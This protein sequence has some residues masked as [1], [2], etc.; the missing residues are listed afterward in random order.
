MRIAASLFAGVAALAAASFCSSTFAIAA[1]ISVEPEPV[2]EANW[3]VSIHGG[4]KF[5]EDWDD[6]SEA[7]ILSPDATFETED[8]WRFGGSIGYVFSSFLALE[9]E[10]SYLRQ[11]FDQLTEDTE[12]EPGEIG[13][14]LSVLTGMV[15]IIAG[16]PLGSFV[17]PYVGA[18]I[19]VAHVSFDTDVNIN[20]GGTVF[21]LDDSDNSFAAQAFAGL[22]LMLSDRVAIG[23]R[24]RIL[25]VKDVELEDS[26]DNKHKLDPERI[27]SAEVVLTFGF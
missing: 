1:D 8:G 2:P 27:H 24:Y 5:D 25:H 9:G 3:Y 11:D 21:T 22:N 23:G 7:Y 15:N 17:Q 13:G 12:P 10:V 4:V 18:G 20:F 19:G 16:V 6:F 14:D 26:N